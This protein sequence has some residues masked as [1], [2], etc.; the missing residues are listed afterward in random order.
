MPKVVTSR[1]LPVFT[2]M[3][4][5]LTDENF[6]VFHC[7]RCQT[8]VIITDHDLFEVPR[9]KTDGAMVLDGRKV[10]IRLNTN[11]RET[12]NLVRRPNGVERQYVHECKNCGQDV[13]YTSTPH[14]QDLAL[15]YVLDT[16]VEVPWHKKK[17]PWTCNVC[18]YICQSEMHLEA[19]RKQ[20]QHFD[21]GAEEEAKQA[22]QEAK[23]IIV[24]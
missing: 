17:T 8:H 23:P 19:H 14:D 22:A 13:A 11:R 7:K 10:V 12:C 15:F 20:R 4:Q 5:K 2:N 3:K 6:N 9:R 16:A 18:G 1:R 21:D 24:G